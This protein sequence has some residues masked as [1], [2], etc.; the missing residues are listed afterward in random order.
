MKSFFTLWGILISL[1]L[2]AQEKLGILGTIV[3]TGNEPVPYAT[4]VFLDADRKVVTYGVTDERGIFLASGL[5]PGKTYG[6]EISCVGYETFRDSLT[7]TGANANKSGVCMETFRIKK[8][9]LL[10]EAV[11]RAGD[12][13]NYLP[14]RITYDVE[15]DTA[16]YRS[17]AMQIIEKLP[18]ISIDRTSGKLQVM[19]GSNYTITVNGKKSLFLSEANQYV[20]RLLEAEKMKQIELVL[21]PSG[22]YEGKTAV[23]NIVTKGNLPDGVVG[24]LG[25]DLNHEM[26]RPAINITSKIKNFIY[27]I[28]YDTEYS[29]YHKL[30]AYTRVTNHTSS[31]HHLTETDKTEWS[32]D[33]K[34]HVTLNTSYDLAPS[35]ILTLSGDYSF[36]RERVYSDEHTTRS[37][38]DRAV[39]SA[40]DTKIRNVMKNNAFN[41]ALNYQKT[42]RDRQDQLL[43]ATYRVEHDQDND[44]YRSLLLDDAHPSG[45]LQPLTNRL[46]LTE[47][48]L[49]ADYSHS[50]GER[51]A[52]FLTAKGVFRHYESDGAVYDADG[53]E[54]G[55]GAHLDYNQ[56]VYSL[57]A[58]YTLRYKNFMAMPRLVFEAT[59]N[60][61]RFD[62]QSDRQGKSF[63]TLMPQLTLRYR[64]KQKSTLFLSYTR[65]SFR[66]DIRYLNPFVNDTDPN[67]ILVGN[68]HLKPETGHN[69]A[70]RYLLAA[71]KFNL[72]LAAEY[73]TSANAVHAYDFINPDGI[74]TTT[75][76]NIGKSE[77]LTFELFARYAPSRRFDLSFDGRARHSKYCNAGTDYPLWNFR[78]HASATVFL[79]PKAFAQ[80]SGWLNPM[81]TSLQSSKYHYYIGYT[82]RLG[83]NFTPRLNLMLD[84]E[85]FARKHLT[86]E[87]ERS[88]PDFHYYEKRELYGR[89]V[90]LTF[91]YNF[92]RLKSS[93]K[94]SGRSIT[95]GDRRK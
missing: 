93:V 37:D 71:P 77:I 50:F 68:P 65:P 8:G 44:R 61:M 89:S 90:V 18:F 36:Y 69:I 6:V 43:T 17:S 4:I 15:L 25:A 45:V 42:F 32:R 64:L 7:L 86:V 11:V 12:P 92:G 1:N 39:V 51:H 78:A 23:I 84:V 58:N 5:Y 22:R 21:E 81:S 13:L 30:D 19:G 47:H 73:S 49:G 91:T 2:C 29:Y 54:T 56:S 70:L 10:D 24:E 3:T 16:A 41:G 72:R 94:A 75:Y 52:L 88:T 40:F 74:L 66:P 31:E 80:A 85:K 63:F 87:E 33:N 46:H 14:D 95:N 57:A 79:T 53:R 20:A 60:R 83:Y 38:A 76:G 82:L 55:Q 28:G 59:D 67:H 27:N 48:T 26:A 34:H 62:A 9:L 35:Q